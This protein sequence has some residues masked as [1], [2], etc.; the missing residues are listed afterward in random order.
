[1]KKDLVYILLSICIIFVIYFIFKNVNFNS[2]KEGMT[3]DASGNGIAGNA[4]KYAAAI[5]AKSVS[6]TDQLLIN[7]YSSDYESAIVNMEDL[8][9]N[10]MLKTVLSVD[11]K[12]PEKSL[13]TLNQL[14]QSQTALN[15]VMKYVDSK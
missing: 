6:L 4:N 11:I 10:L 5:K 8:I 1:M 3:S 9:N 13:L 2:V 7:K 15:D 14:H 12:N